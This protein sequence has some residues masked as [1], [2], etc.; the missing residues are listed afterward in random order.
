MQRDR[1]ASRAWAWWLAALGTSALARAPMPEAA[2]SE[3]PED[4]ALGLVLGSL[5]GDAAGG[6]PE[7]ASPER[8]AEVGAPFR[9]WVAGQRLPDGRAQPEAAALAEYAAGLELMAYGALRPLPEPYGQWRADAP[10]G[11]LTDDS[12]QKLILIA[13]LEQSLESNAWPI[14][15]AEFAREFIAWSEAWEA[16]H[17]GQGLVGEWLA[18]YTMSARWVLGERD[19][20]RARPPERLWGGLGTC[21]GQMALLPIAAVYPGDPE[22]AYLA[23]YRLAFFDNADG[24]DLNAAIVAGLAS[25]AGR[26]FDSHAH[27]WAHIKA[28]MRRTDPYGYAR[29]PWVERSVDLWLNEVERVVQEADRQPA[30]LRTFI[31]RHLPKRQWW[32]AHVTFVMAAIAAEATDL[33]PTAAMRLAI[34]L[35]WDTDSTAQLVGAWA[36]A[37]L[38]STAYPQAMREAVTQQME[39][40]YGVRLTDLMATLTRCRTLA[41]QGVELVRER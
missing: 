31:E 33:H 29:V 7:F 30:A 5:I 15:E 17:P 39:A 4:R 18:E 38:G 25:A 13:M 23:A 21:A 37:A 12:R 2:P 19:A 9:R 6:P 16:A 1:R 10:P 36:G 11:T 28:T 41:A 26:A 24:R 32:E 20:A 14:G 27:A 40:D 34:E 3:L 35:G 8:L 22:R